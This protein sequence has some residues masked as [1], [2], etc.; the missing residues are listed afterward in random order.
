MKDCYVGIPQAGKKK[1]LN[2]TARRLSELSRGQ[3]S[4]VQQNNSTNLGKCSRRLSAWLPL[5]GTLS[6]FLAS[7]PQ[8]ATGNHSWHTKFCQ[9]PY[10]RKLR[11]ISTQHR[12]Q[13]N[14]HGVSHYKLVTY[15]SLEGE[16]YD[17]QQSA[18]FCRMA[19]SGEWLCT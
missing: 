14:K 17:N 15:F 1:W 10:S 3:L 8:C 4:A 18:L 5:E 16:V 12:T 2:Y 11:K 19:H 6:V 9:F 7:L 13:D